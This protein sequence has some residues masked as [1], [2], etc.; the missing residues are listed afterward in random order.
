[1][2]I[3][4]LLDCNG[5]CSG[6]LVVEK[7]VAVR[8][9]LLGCVREGKKTGSRLAWL[10]LRVQDCFFWSGVCASTSYSLSR[11]QGDRFSPDPALQFGPFLLCN[12]VCRLPRAAGLDQ[13]V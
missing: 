7:R 1:M 10:T 13:T 5:I 12:A 8:C 2:D 6:P 3:H 11:L 4:T 9:V